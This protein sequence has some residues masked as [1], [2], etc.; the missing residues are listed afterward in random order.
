MDRIDRSHAMIGE[1]Q[2]EE[3]NPWIDAAKKSA[4]SS[5]ASGIASDHDALQQLWSNGR[6]GGQIT[7]LELVKRQMHDLAWLDPRE[8]RLVGAA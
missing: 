6:T 4:L 2:R 5:F 3:L 8:A 7:K 1:R